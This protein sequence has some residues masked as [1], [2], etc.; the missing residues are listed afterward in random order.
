ML[1]FLFLTA[2]VFD[3]LWDKFVAKIQTLLSKRVKVLA[4]SQ[5]IQIIGYQGIGKFE[6]DSVSFSAAL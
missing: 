3:D 5:G 1:G 6:L 4:I 2:S